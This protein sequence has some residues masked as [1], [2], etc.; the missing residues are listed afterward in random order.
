[1]F[2][3]TIVYNGVLFILCCMLIFLFLIIE[4]LSYFQ[5]FRYVYQYIKYEEHPVM[6]IL[7]YILDYFCPIN[8]IM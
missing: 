3:L 8:S 2:F 4:C 5:F 1:M 6:K 7:V